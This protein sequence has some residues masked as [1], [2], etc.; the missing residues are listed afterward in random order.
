[1]NQHWHLSYSSDILLGEW[2][3]AKNIQPSQSHVAAQ[4]AAGANDWRT[5]QRTPG[6]NRPPGVPAHP[7]LQGARSGRDPDVRPSLIATDG[8]TNSQLSTRKLL[9][10]HVCLYAFP[11][12]LPL[13]LPFCLPRTEA[14]LLP[15]ALPVGSRAVWAPSWEEECGTEGHGDTAT[16]LAFEGNVRRE[17][18]GQTGLG[19]PCLRRSS[20]KIPWNTL[21]PEDHAPDLSPSSHHGVALPGSSR[22][23]PVPHIYKEQRPGGCEPHAR[24]DTSLPPSGWATFQF[25]LP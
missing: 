5:A 3:F 7:E 18:L 10:Q 17:P 22:S 14:G 24:A 21:R 19:A 9:P 1:M 16:Q 12:P 8:G 23:A 6:R 11:G 2:L 15:P 13:L 20:R 25:T 4:G